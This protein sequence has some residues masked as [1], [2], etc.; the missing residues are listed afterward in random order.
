MQQMYT[1]FGLDFNCKLRDLI[2]LL[3]QLKCYISVQLFKQV[4]KVNQLFGVCL[5]ICI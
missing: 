3:I 4:I 1:I 2:F 5:K